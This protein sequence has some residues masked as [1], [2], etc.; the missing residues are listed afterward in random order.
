MLFRSPKLNA[1]FAVRVAASPLRAVISGGDVRI[2]DQNGQVILDATPSQGVNTAQQR[3]SYV[4]SCVNSA[5][6]P[7]YNQS[8]Q[9]P[10]TLP[11]TPTLSFPAS[12]LDPADVYSFSLTLGSGANSTRVSSAGMRL[13]QVEDATSDTT[14]PQPIERVQVAIAASARS[15]A[16]N[17]PLTLTGVVTRPSSAAST[18]P[19]QYIWTLLMGDLDNNTVTAVSSWSQPTL[20]LNAE[21]AD[22]F[23]EPGTF[24]RFRLTVIQ[25]APSNSVF[26]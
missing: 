21:R 16:H 13:F 2:A 15:I 8:S 1:T 4:W 9:I 22:G 7:C 12:A 25:A 6:R 19:L 18:A 24:Y 14:Q 17:S 26:E 10:I 5:Q 20:A 23:F 3:Q 11:Q